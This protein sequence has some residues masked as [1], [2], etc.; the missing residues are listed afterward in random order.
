MAE[1]RQVEQ[2]ASNNGEN[3][4]QVSA[5]YVRGNLRS[6]RNLDAIKQGKKRFPKHLAAWCAHSSTKWGQ[7]A[8]FIILEFNS[9]AISLE[10]ETS[11][12]SKGDKKRESLSNRNRLW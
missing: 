6:I 7:V 10:D 9:G 2:W 8:Y 1:A 12:V 11:Q 3:S 5:T 4:H